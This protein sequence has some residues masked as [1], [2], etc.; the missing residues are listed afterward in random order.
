MSTTQ[1]LPGPRAPA[2]R[3]AVGI[4]LLLCCALIAAMVMLGGYTRL[5]GSGL[6]MVDWGP[7]MGILPPLTESDWQ[8]AF[9]AYQQSPEYRKIN[10][11][12]DLAGFKRIFYIEYAHRML[13]RLTGVVFLVPLLYFALRRRIDRRLMAGLGAIFVLGALQG[14]MGWYMV[15]SGLVDRPHVSQYRLTAH[16]VFAFIIYGLVWWLA[17]SQLLPGRNPNML[18]RDDSRRFEWLVWSLLG[19][20]GVT[21]LT[22]GLVAGLRAGFAY[23]TFPLMGG[24]LIAEGAFSMEPLVKNFFAN[25]VLVQFGHRWLANLVVVLSLTVWLT[26]RRT[27]LPPRAELGAHLLLAAAL[28]QFGLGVTTL[29]LRVPVALGVL[30]QAGAL[31]LFSAGLFLVHALRRVPV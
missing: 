9:R 16:L 3:P 4:W 26:A 25:A 8:A 13:G 24:R 29:L 19:L 18:R 20:I 31:L 2:Q 14:L 15:K 10:V 12:M 30:H 7:I 1:D 6:S 22:G 11:G 17:L 23:N 28:L 21:L 27:S 5:T